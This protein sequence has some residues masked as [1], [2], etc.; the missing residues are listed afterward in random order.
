MIRFSTF[1]VLAP[2]NPALVLGWGDLS[3]SP[4]MSLSWVLSVGIRQY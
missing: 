3:Q 2:W 4:L 1:M